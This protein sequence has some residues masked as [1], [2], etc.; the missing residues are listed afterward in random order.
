MD[1]S[2]TENPPDP[3][4]PVDPT[5]PIDSG[6]TALPLFTAVNKGAWQ[7]GLRNLETELKAAGRAEGRGGRRVHR[8]ATLSAPGGEGATRTLSIPPAD[9]AVARSRSAR[10]A[11]G[12]IGR[13]CRWLSRFLCVPSRWCVNERGDVTPAG[14]VAILG[15][16]AGERLTL[17]P[18]P[19]LRWGPG[20]RCTAS[21]GA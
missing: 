15:V 8:L 10:R 17:L 1:T 6:V 12:A 13:S 5:G 19:H 21:R 9:R 3:T 18:G 2:I 20:S 7:D 16:G 4:G 11:E 14:G